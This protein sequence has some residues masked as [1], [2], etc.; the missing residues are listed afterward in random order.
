MWL[1]VFLNFL[2]IIRL[3]QFLNKGLPTPLA[4]KTSYN[5]CPLIPAFDPS[6]ND[7]KMAVKDAPIKA[8]NEALTVWPSPISSP[9]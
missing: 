6:T 9:T 4:L 2:S 1:P 5:V 3:A 7:S 8:C